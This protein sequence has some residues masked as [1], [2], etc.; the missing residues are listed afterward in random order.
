MSIGII[1]IREIEIRIEMAREFL[2]K[3]I[4]ENLDPKEILKASEELD[5]LIVDYLIN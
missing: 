5:K 3:R 2:Y 1:R 4:E